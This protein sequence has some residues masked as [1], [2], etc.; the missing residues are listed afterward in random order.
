GISSPY[1]APEC[2][3][4]SVNTSVQSPEESTKIVID[5]LIDNHIIEKK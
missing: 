1:E 5:Y 3:E 2:P 4:I